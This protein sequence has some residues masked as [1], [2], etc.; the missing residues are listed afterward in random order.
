MDT[1]YGLDDLP[2]AMADKDRLCVCLCVNV[3]ERERGRE[4]ERERER[5]EERESQRMMMNLK[6]YID[7]NLLGSRHRTEDKKV[8]R[9]NLDV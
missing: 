7:K 2:R 9:F 1:G 8:W 5:E 3:R 6:F 4:R